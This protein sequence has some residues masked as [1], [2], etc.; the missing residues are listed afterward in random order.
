VAPW[1]KPQRAF[2]EASGCIRFRHRLM[3]YALCLMPERKVGV[4]EAV[5]LDGEHDGGVGV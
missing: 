3:P 2:I 4:P 1:P 5:A